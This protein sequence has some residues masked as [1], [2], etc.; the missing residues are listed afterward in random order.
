MKNKIIY[1]VLA[2]I[3][4]ISIVLTFTI[5]LNV[6]LYYGEGY[7]IKFTETTT[8]ETADVETIVKE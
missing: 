5:G 3:F 4:I 2:V 7:T 1:G 8:I 6:D